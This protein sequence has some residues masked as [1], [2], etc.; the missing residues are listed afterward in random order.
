MPCTYNQRIT[1]AE[2]IVEK[3]VVRYAGHERVAEKSVEKLI[4]V[5]R[6][7]LVSVIRTK[8]VDLVQKVE[9]VIFE[10]RVKV[11]E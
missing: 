2:K 5:E 1:I 6:L 10:D 3:P 8:V 4:E 7:V 11:V 9:K